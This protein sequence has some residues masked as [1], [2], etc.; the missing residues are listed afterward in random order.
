MGM[1]GFVELTTRDGYKV[2]IRVTKI[3]CI[4]SA[5]DGTWVKYNNIPVNVRGSYDE[6]TRAVSD[7]MASRG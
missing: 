5:H 2:T 7:A 3:D 6:V 4:E 1:P